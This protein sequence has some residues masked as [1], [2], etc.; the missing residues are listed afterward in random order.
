L[1]ARTTQQLTKSTGVPSL[2][3]TTVADRTGAPFRSKVRGVRIDK[4][5][6]SRKQGIPNLSKPRKQESSEAEDVVPK[7]ATS[8]TIAQQETPNAISAEDGSTSQLY[9]EPK[10][11]T[12]LTMRKTLLRM[13]LYTVKR[14]P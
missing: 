4:A 10:Q 7:R 9:A 3:A 8:G 14:S 6:T 5:K 1:L 2:D 12:R 13:A 11:P